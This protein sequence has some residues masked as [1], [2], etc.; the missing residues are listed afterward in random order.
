MR[1]GLHDH[2][3]NRATRDRLCARIAVTVLA[4]AIVA[5]AFAQPVVTAGV[6]AYFAMQANAPPVT[7]DPSL[8]LTDA[9][10]ANI[11]GA[12]VSIASGFV[13]GDILATNT[14]GT[15]VSAS[16]DGATGV[17]T[18]GGLD[19]IA[20]YRQIMRFV[21]FTPGSGNSARTIRWQATD[22][23][24]APS[25]VAT[26]TVAFTN[27]AQFGS[28]TI[29][30]GRSGAG[31]AVG[32][33]ESAWFIESECSTCQPV[34]IGRATPGG[35]IS[36]FPANGNR[37]PA[38]IASLPGGGLWFTEPGIGANFIGELSI[39]GAETDFPLTAQD[40][41]FGISNGPDGA[42]WFADQ[43]FVGAGNCPAQIGRITPAGSVSRFAI[44]SGNLPVSVAPT[45]FG[46]QLLFTE[47]TAAASNLCNNVQ[48]A[49]GAITTTG[50]VTEF[51]IRSG[52]I[53]V[54]TAAGGYSGIT[55][56][57]YFIETDPTGANGFIGFANV[58]QNFFHECPVPSGNVPVAI[59]TGPDGAAYFSEDTN[60]IGR[61]GSGINPC[62]ITEIPLPNNVRPGGIAALFNLPLWFIDTANPAIDLLPNAIT[63]LAA[64]V[65]PTTR[66]VMVGETA[67]A[68]ATIANAG[69]GSASTCSIAPQT[70]IPATF[71]YQTTNPATNAV[72]GT[73]NTPAN[74][75][76]GGSQS[77][78]IALTPTAA[79]PPTKVTFNFT[80]A[81]TDSVSLASSLVDTLQLSASTTPVAD[82]IAI[83]ASN[84]PG[85]VDIPGTNGTG[86]FA[87]ATDNLGADATITVSANTN[88]L[89]VLIG[90]SVCQTNPATGICLAP[91]APSVTLDIPPN[92]EP[93]FGVFVAGQGP[94]VDPLA[95]DRV[96]VVFT[97]ASGTLRGGTSVA[98]RTQ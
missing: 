11:T 4:S 26:S 42:L 79:F 23:N 72:T 5:P 94:I 10:T 73:P 8:A 64:A 31:L 77:Y 43:G 86:D 67:T 48:N 47:S 38:A 56:N 33:D 14:T 96:Y 62:T 84:D 1:H 69:P 46:T 37:I 53:P 76:P 80:C 98:V 81:T 2:R 12:A 40:G 52:N 97:D 34:A 36:E 35:S 82:V 90:L 55:I 9:T 41:P 91:P 49:I 6:T 61:V 3:D 87:V 50:A 54:A 58:S 57:G 45:S 68:F 83:A 66:S 51:P 27:V 75:S 30:S 16:Y 29:P 63:A 60:L 22:A 95:E 65:L 88:G 92:A 78:V 18:L 70:T 19:T 89:P 13:P 93:T 17:L 44:P 59:A 85:Y 32:A 7:L 24:N 20:D 74:I 21:T 25:N 39:G 28:Y 71:L 15:S